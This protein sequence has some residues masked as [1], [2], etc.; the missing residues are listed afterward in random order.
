M[1]VSNRA[2]CSALTW[3]NNGDWWSLWSVIQYYLQTLLVCYLIKYWFS[4]LERVFFGKWILYLTVGLN[5]IWRISIIIKCKFCAFLHNETWKAGSINDM[6]KIEITVR[7]WDFFFV[8][9]WLFPLNLVDGLCKLLKLVAFNLL[10]FIFC[11][12][13]WWISVECFYSF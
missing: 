11:A 3:Y 7:I 9:T 8:V 5:S 6:T 1:L 4:C 12:K 13:V 2:M 10:K